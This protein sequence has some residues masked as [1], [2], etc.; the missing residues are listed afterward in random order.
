MI[1]K[2]RSKGCGTGEVKVYKNDIEV[3]PTMEESGYCKC[4]IMEDGSTALFP[5]SDW[6]ISALKFVEL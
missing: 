1:V 3:V 2:V 4:L 6:E 5:A